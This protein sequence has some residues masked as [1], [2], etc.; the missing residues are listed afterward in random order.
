MMK[1]SR[2][3]FLACAG[4]FA[5]VLTGFAL[6][7]PNREP[8]DLEEVKK[9]FLERFCEYMAK[10]KPQIRDWKKGA[11]PT[12]EE[13]EAVIRRNPSIGNELLRIRT[14]FYQELE[15]DENKRN[16]FRKKRSKHSGAPFG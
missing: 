5:A 7:D 6:V 3:F 15:T 2:T 16:S 12:D 13:I 11:L 14:E 9:A 10:K 8:V 1:S 4:C